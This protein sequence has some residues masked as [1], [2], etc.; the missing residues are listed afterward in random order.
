MQTGQHR[1]RRQDGHPKNTS[2]V[3][4]H[5]LTTRCFPSPVCLRCHPCLPRR[6]TAAFFTKLTAVRGILYQTTPLQ[7][8]DCSQR[9]KEKRWRDGDRINLLG[10]PPRY[11]LL[12][13]TTQRSCCAGEKNTTAKIVSWN[14]C[15]QFFPFPFHTPHSSNHQPTHPHKRERSTTKPF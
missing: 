1:N 3:Y 4:S 5:P 12:P 2:G 13:K 6:R 14:S 7:Q 15:L 8:S 9:G 11:S 10:F